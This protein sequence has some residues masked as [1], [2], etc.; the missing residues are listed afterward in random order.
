MITL[1]TDFV[2]GVDGFIPPLTYKQIVRSNKVAVYQRFT[3]DG[4]FKDFET[5]VIRIIPKGTSIFNQPPT[6][7]DAEKYAVTSSWG[8]TGF[9]FKNLLAAQEK[10]KELELKDI[11][12]EKD[13]TEI[14]FQI[15]NGLFSTNELAQF[16]KVAYPEASLFLKEKLLNNSIRF[17]RSERR[18]AKGKE[19]NLYEKTP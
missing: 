6:E 4:I 15:P 19:T 16:N 14:V 7:E 11:Q 2:S 10:M 17:V 3:K 18:Q 13:E 12:E 5:I 8:K 9:S 1:A